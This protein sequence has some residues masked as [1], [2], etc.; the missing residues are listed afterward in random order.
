MQVT[1]KDPPSIH[2]DVT[3]KNETI[4]LFLK[5]SCYDSKNEAC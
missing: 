2:C 1:Y 4:S 3:A 5:H